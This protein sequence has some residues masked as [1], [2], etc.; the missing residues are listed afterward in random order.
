MAGHVKKKPPS[1]A[2]CQPWPK[3]CKHPMLLLGTHEDFRKGWLCPDCGGIH[4]GS[5]RCP[6]WREEPCHFCAKP[7]A[8]KAERRFDEVGHAYHVDCYEWTGEGE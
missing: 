2:R 3:R 5:A 8:Y 7:I 4:Y 1:G 6:Y